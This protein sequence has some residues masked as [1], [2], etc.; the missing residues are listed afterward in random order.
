[1]FI[2]LLAWLSR[3]VEI[4]P[5]L[6]GGTPRDSPRW[7]IA[8][9]FVPIAFLWKPYTVVREVW[10][11][12]ATSTRAA[13]GTPVLAWWLLWIG[14]V[15]VSNVVNRLMTAETIGDIQGLFYA[16]AVFQGL[17]LGAALSGF[18]VVR[19]I[20]ARADERALE[21]GFDA[22]APLYPTASQ[23]ASPP[24]GPDEE[25]RTVEGLGTAPS[26]SMEI[27]FCPECGTPRSGTARFCVKCGKDLTAA[28]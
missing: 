1:M 12:L 17:A 4:V 6:G 19:E 8:W 20:Q 7:A 18:V 5:A 21:F 23:R 14:A 26:P 28:P 3:T 2:T 22:A 13:A 27:S 16:N 11:R 15:F 10:D 25:T 24:Q 9:W